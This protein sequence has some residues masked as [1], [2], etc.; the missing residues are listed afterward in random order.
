[1][2][3]V[4]TTFELDIISTEYQEE[5]GGASAD[6]GAATRPASVLSVPRGKLHLRM[7]NLGH[8]VDPKA[9]TAS[10]EMLPYL[11]LSYNRSANCCLLNDMLCRLLQLRIEELG[12][13][14]YL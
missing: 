5:V 8:P 1:M 7:A 14:R 12:F 11:L 9:N 4:Q 6:P 13:V 3:A 2:E 10:R